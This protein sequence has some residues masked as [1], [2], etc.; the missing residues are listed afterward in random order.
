MP[1]KVL[2]IS[3][4]EDGT[5]FAYTEEPNHF[6]T[7]THS[8]NGLGRDLSKWVSP[9]VFEEECNVR[10]AL[11]PGEWTSVLIKEIL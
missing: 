9:D 11:K 5:V 4:D 7:V 8:K 3:H 2:I 6:V 10:E 1:N